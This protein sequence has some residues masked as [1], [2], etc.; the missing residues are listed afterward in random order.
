[1]SVPGVVNLTVERSLLAHTGLV[2]GTCCR[3]GADVVF[4]CLNTQCISANK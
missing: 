2:S 4:E 3:G 1:M